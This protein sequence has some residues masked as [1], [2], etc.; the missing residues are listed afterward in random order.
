MDRVGQRKTCVVEQKKGLPQVDEKR[1]KFR[2]D[3][4]TIAC[5]KLPQVQDGVGSQN[6]I[7]QV[8]EGEIR[9]VDGKEGT[10]I[11]FKSIE[12]G[13]KQTAS[14]SSD[15]IF[16]LSKDSR[17]SAYSLS[18]LEA[19]FQNDLSTLEGQVS[20]LSTYKDED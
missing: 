14:D 6:G 7:V 10:L 9:I 19:K 8:T 16:V 5:F 17:V 20:A 11:D 18:S 3:V 4:A 12:A 2:F 15:S 13:I 1:I